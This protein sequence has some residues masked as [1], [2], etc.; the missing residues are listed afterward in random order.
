MAGW[1][2][3]NAQSEQHPARV[4]TSPLSIRKG[5]GAGEEEVAQQLTALAAFSEV[6]VHFL[7]HTVA[8]NQL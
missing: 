1:D 2:S 3:S 7:A 6:R 5:R 8:H 4:W